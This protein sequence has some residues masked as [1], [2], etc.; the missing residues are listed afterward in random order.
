MADSI[1]LDA[2]AKEAIV[3]TAPRRV[4]RVELQLA[5]QAQISAEAEAAM[6]GLHGGP[7]K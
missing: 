6:G 4:D 5:A 3:E 1:G 2:Q 7:C